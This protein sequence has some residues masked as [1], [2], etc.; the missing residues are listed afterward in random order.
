MLM[1]PAPTRDRLLQILQ[2]A[3]ADVG[4][5]TVEVATRMDQST[6]YI[7]SQ[8][9]RM[10]AYGYVRKITPG[11]SPSPHELNRWVVRERR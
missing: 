8:L 9:G 10:R 3:P 5:T 1:R 4:L 6:K 7:A 11:P 2:T